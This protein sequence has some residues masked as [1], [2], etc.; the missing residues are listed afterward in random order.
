M[1]QFEEALRRNERL[2]AEGQRLSHT[3]SFGW[4]ASSDEHFWSAETFSIFEFDPSSKVSMPMILG[5]VHPQDRP[6][7]KMA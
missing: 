7:V 5:R 3:G 4:S 2:L 6:G 1:N